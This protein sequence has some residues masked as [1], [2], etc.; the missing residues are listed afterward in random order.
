MDKTPEQATMTLGDRMAQWPE[1]YREEGRRER[2]ARSVVWV[3]TSLRRQ[4]VLRF[5]EMVGEQVEALLS[6][7]DDWDQIST[8]AELGVTAKSGTASSTAPPQSSILRNSPPVLVRDALG[9][10]AS[11]PPLAPQGAFLATTWPK[12]PTNRS[13]RVMGPLINVGPLEG[14]RLALPTRR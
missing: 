8:V 13:R 10:R 5:G 6:N 11:R 12:K 7:T 14:G 9:G 3:R 2:A 1:K 4:T